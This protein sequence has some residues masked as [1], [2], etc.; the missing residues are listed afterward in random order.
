MQP[1]H[2]VLYCHAVKEGLLVIKEVGVRE[3]QLVCYAVV[4][5]Q[6][7]LELTVGQ[8]LIPPAL[9]EIHGDGVVLRRKTSSRVKPQR[10]HIRP[11]HAA[12][13][14]DHVTR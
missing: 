9:L 12:F 13:D 7:E 5:S 14:P 11:K 2:S 8:T 10:G 6:V 4:Q 1:D 3:P